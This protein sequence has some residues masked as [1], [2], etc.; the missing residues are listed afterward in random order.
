MGFIKQVEHLKRYK[1]LTGLLI[2]YGRF[3]IVE[4]MNLA[5]AV[6][7]IPVQD[8][9][10]KPED[11]AD[12]LEKLGPTYIKLGQFL[13]TRADF[14]PPPYLDALSRLQDDVAPIPYEQIEEIVTSE[15][16]VRISKAFG[17]FHQDPMASA[18]LGQV[19]LAT[20]R[21]GK[22]VAVKVQ[23]PDIREQI[24]Y[25]L[26][27]FTSIAEF[28]E[29]HTDIGQQLML[30]ATLEEFRK[31]MLRELDYTLESQNLLTLRKNL[32]NF[33]HIIVPSPVSDY[34]STRVL[35][36]D[37]IQG[38]NISK[39]SP[40]ANLELNGSKLA[41]ELFEA[42]LQ[43]ILVDG[44]YHADPHPG[45]IFLTE[46]HHLALID[47][48][49]IARIPERL[50]SKMMRLLV[51]ISE[52]KGGE[53]ANHL[54]EIGTIQQES[55]EKVF[56]EQVEDLVGRYHDSNLE[57]IQVGRLI[58]EVTK[59]SRVN[60]IRL[61][62][63]L[64]MLGKTLMNLDKVGQTLDPNFN[65]NA[66]I[67]RHAAELIRKKMQDST[68][69]GAMYST[70]LETKEFVEQLPSRVNKILDT[71][72]NNEFTVNANTI[73]EKYFMSGLKEIANRLTLGII[74]AALIIGAALLMRVDTAFTLFGY[75][76][77]AIIFFLLAGISGFVLAVKI[78]FRSD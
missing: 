1:D 78:L 58:L 3:D 42:Y 68:S 7:E 29:A 70:L 41:D 59:V 34:T 64:V 21:D 9:A 19:H 25:D 40:L 76:G 57:Q 4:Q 67:R 31:A 2:K 43:Q 49:M 51:A 65:P 32:A 77:L 55:D 24:I 45:N 39:L 11:L 33:D 75:P 48:G 28:L 6:T 30:Q 14:L 62:N 26:D 74:L 44:F 17:Y 47:L 35:T 71:L 66:S 53:A 5:D 52:G 46:D 20:L 27:A 36:M 54:I 8:G 12:D 61:P 16:G 50:Q 23:R 37:Y 69:I 15:L 18:S 63:E 13:S 10:S 72:A 38:K 73:D 60:G 56:C 22:K